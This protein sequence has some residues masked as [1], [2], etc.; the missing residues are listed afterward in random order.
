MS[1]LLKLVKLKPFLGRFAQLEVSKLF[2]WKIPWRFVWVLFFLIDNVSS[3][4]NQ[5]LTF[6]LNLCW[7]FL[8]L[9]C[10]CWL[11]FF[12]LRKVLLWLFLL[13]LVRLLIDLFFLGLSCLCQPY[14][15]AFLDEFRFMS[16]PSF[17]LQSQPLGGF[18]DWGRR[19]SVD[20]HYKQL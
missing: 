6:R 1:H 3:K 8:L 20:F 13:F 9:D 11:G 18:P 17:H 4:G 19:Q 14:F 16:K 10:L 7:S 2:F 5:L 12:F 15:P